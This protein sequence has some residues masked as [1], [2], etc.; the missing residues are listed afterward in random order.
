MLKE[1][2]AEFPAENSNAWMKPE[3]FPSALVLALL[4]EKPGELSPVVTA[5]NPPSI[6]LTLVFL[7]SFQWD[8]LHSLRAS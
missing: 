2:G 8:A 4:I 1:R 7:K 6:L 5:L 3:R